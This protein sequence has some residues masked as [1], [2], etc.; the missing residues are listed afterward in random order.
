MDQLTDRIIAAIAAKSQPR[1][2]RSCERS[3]SHQR[4][5]SQPRTNFGP[6]KDLCYYHFK[7]KLKAK[8]DLDLPFA[9]R[10]YERE[11]AAEK[12]D[13]KAPCL[14]IC[15]ASLPGTLG[16]KSLFI[17][18]L[19]LHL[20]FLIDTGAEV[21]VLPEDGNCTSPSPSLTLHAANDSIIHAYGTR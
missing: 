3:S 10:K 8:K 13:K 18:D 1:Q 21:S 14:D 6:N 4:L 15:E 5:R 17:K 20:I 11:W 16:T 7:Y 2:S 12:K 19:S 9:W